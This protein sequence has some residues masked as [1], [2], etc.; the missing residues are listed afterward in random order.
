M[1]ILDV[2]RVLP[3]AA[4]AAPPGLAQA[5]ADAAGR[6]FGSAPARTW[7]R[8]RVLPAAAYAENNS[9]ISADGLPVFVTV[10][11]AH[12]PEGDVLAAQV[13]ALTDAVA[14]V[15]NIDAV[16]VHVQVAPPGAGR[17]A[18]GGQLVR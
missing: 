12:V 14:A 3:H 15:L 13:H 9:T 4:D 2:E 11:Q 5:L 16:R 6:V 1:P 18:F 7:V 10:L 17:Q 8:L